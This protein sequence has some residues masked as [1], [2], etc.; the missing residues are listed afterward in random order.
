MLP[1]QARPPA[2]AG[3]VAA[4]AIQ[5]TPLVHPTVG[6]ELRAAVDETQAAFGVVPVGHRIA[7]PG[8]PA[9]QPRPAV[10]AT[11]PVRFGPALGV[12]SLLDPV[13]H[14]PMSASGGIVG[15]PSLTDLRV[16]QEL[17]QTSFC[18]N[19]NGVAGPRCACL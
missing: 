11:A 16:T 18:N 4:P 3:A 6:E 2:R 9:A 5:D 10:S 13:P 1:D 15:R 14:R 19:T 7:I 17:R 12:R 8:L